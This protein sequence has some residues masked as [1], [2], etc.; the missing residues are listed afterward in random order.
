MLYGIRTRVDCMTPCKWA[1]LASFARVI[2]AVCSMPYIPIIIRAIQM[3]RPIQVSHPIRMTQLVWTVHPARNLA[4]FPITLRDC[5]PKHLISA[6][7]QKTKEISTREEH[8]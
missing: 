8:Y 1:T 3:S 6:S 4:I 2:F 5:N 7:T